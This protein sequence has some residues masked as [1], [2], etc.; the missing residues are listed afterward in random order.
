MR[1]TG[2]DKH[3][4][5]INRAFNAQRIADRDTDELIGLCRGL[6]ADGIVT[7]DEVEFLQ[8]WVARTG[9]VRSQYPGNLIHARLCEY[10]EDGVLDADEKRELFDFM[11]QLTGHIDTPLPVAAS[12]SLPFDSPMPELTIDRTSFCLTGRFAYGTRQDCSNL[13]S[14]LGGYL[15]STPTQSCIVVVGYLGS[16]DWIHSSHG[17]KIEKAVSFREQGHPVAIVP[18]DHWI[19]CCLAQREGF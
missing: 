19:E 17:R 10:L 1:K 2:L 12:T 9:S 4:Q 5:P 11:A 3:G 13:I 6:M 16:S 18:E 8:Q 15:K 7:Q 14:S